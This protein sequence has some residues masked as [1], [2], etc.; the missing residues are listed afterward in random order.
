VL[1]D[2]PRSTPRVQGLEGDVIVIGAGI[3][4]L[5]AAL[6]LKR[7]SRRVIVLDARSLREGESCRTTAH[8]SEVPDT[9]LSVLLRRF[10][11]DDT[12]LVI[13]GQRHAIAY[14]QRLQ[15]EIGAEC[16]FQRLPGFLYAEAGDKA[17]RQVLEAETAAAD[18]LGYGDL[19]SR[20][21]PARFPIAGALRFEQQAQFRPGAYVAALEA[22]IYG[23]GSLVARGVRV[24]A[25][26]DRADGRC[27]VSTN[28]GELYA[29]R[30]ILATDVPIGDIAAVRSKLAAYRS[31]AIAAPVPRPLGALLWDLAVPYRHARTARIGNRNYL[32]AGGGDHRVGEEID[33][34]QVLAELDE[35]ARSHFG[36]LVVTHHWSG[37]I[38]ETV[39]G[40]PYVGAEAADSRILFATGLSGNGITNGTLAG[41]VLA[42]LVRGHANPWARLLAPDRARSLASMGR[43]VGRNLAAARRRLTRRIRELVHD[44]ERLPRSNGMLARR[45]GERLAVYR[46][47]TGALRALGAACP[48]GRGHVRWNGAEK[49]WDCP[50]CGSR[51]DLAGAVLNGPAVRGLEPRTLDDPST[52]TAVTAAG[53]PAF[54]PPPV[55]PA[56]SVGAAS[57][58]PA[59]SAAQSQSAP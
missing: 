54:A 38:I 32:I 51:F 25:I 15:Q 40:L 44:I 30:V 34:R 14:I 16:G 49:S 28:A 3:T 46:S 33:T 22:Q 39:D 20:E 27:R 29:E 23:R 12:R 45:Q 1:S 21:I 55:L 9:R 58:V 11:V 36:P 2:R 8:L 53:P 47:A 43:D 5:T 24:H 50:T 17:Q 41:L 35:Y 48:S 18:A 6:S 13:E 26:D 7:A 56:P 42:D 4:G 19:R 37:Q 59:P 52:G 10:G 31:Y 57:V